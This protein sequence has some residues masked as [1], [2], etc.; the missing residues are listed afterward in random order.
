MLQKG[1]KVLYLTNMCIIIPTIIIN[2]SSLKNKTATMRS[3]GP[4]LVSVQLVCIHLPILLGNL[5]YLLVFL[6]VHLQFHQ[7]IY[8]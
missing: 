6:S 3:R 5:D 4:T 7:F 1:G 2:I 8:A